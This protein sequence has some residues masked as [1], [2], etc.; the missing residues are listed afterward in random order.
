MNMHGQ[1]IGNE[2]E[3]SK[4]NEHDKDDVRFVMGFVFE[5]FLPSKSIV[6]DKIR[7][8]WLYIVVN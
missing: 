5:E 8:N 3:Q 7:K 6:K 2:P 1:S 4:L